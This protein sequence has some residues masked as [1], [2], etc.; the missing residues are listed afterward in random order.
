M[1]EQIKLLFFS[2]R[3][4]GRENKIPRPLL[5]EGKYNFIFSDHVKEHFFLGG[6]GGKIELYFS[7]PL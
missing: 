3:F 1:K 4:V 7:R 6:G 5:R 2:R